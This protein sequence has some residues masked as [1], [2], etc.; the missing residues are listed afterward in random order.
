MDET[1]LDEIKMEKTNII[2]FPCFYCEDGILAIWLSPEMTKDLLEVK[3]WIYRCDRCGETVAP[4]IIGDKKKIADE[5]FWRKEKRL[6]KRNKLTTSVWARTQIPAELQKVVDDTD[7]DEKTIV[8]VSCPFC[9]VPVEENDVTVGPAGNKVVPAGSPMDYDGKFIC[10][11][12]K[13][14]VLVGSFFH[15]KDAELNIWLALRSFDQG[16]ATVFDME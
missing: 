3:T 6:P 4:G 10:P 16:Q 2:E 9:G 15:E 5:V 8:V 11:K 12:C 1:K 7:V 13:Q 14:F